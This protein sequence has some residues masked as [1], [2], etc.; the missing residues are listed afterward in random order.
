MRVKRQRSVG[1]TPSVRDIWL[2]LE[3][4]SGPLLIIKLVCGNLAGNSKVDYLAT[5]PSCLV[6]GSP[7]HDIRDSHRLR[8]LTMQHIWVGN[9]PF[10]ESKAFP[11]TNS[12]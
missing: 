11:S 10:F 6:E 12:A 1:R 5:E 8:S 3:N 4:K 9:S 7:R 2:D